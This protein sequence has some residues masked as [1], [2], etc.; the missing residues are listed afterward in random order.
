MDLEELGFFVYMAEQEE[1]DAEDPQ[2]L[3]FDYKGEKQD[4]LV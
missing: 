2:P 4:E 1:Q 3:Q